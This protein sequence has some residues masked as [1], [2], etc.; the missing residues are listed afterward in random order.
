MLAPTLK[1]LG[2]DRG[3]YRLELGPVGWALFSSDRKKRFALGRFLR[4]GLFH[5]KEPTV[6][7]VCGLN[8][9]KAG[10][11][12]N[13]V[14]ITKTE[15]FAELYRCASVL[16]VNL[17][18]TIETDSK[19]AEAS[20]TVE[21]DRAVAAVIEYVTRE[22]VPRTIVAWG[23][24]RLATPS[25]TGLLPKPLL[26]LGRTADGAPRHPSRIAYQTPLE[27]WGPS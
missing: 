14:T 9:S 17:E 25:L 2:L 19:L 11:D 15:G 5:P 12:V 23:S 27:P 4:T 22:A 21:D 7:V 18:P 10:A 16:M 13:D 24:H 26:C 20:A 3:A 6:L 1:D 8:P